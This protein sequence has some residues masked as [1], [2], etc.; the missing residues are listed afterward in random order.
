MSTPHLWRA[1]ALCGILAI[2]VIAQQG[3]YQPY[4]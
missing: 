3:P 2:A 1:C 4:Q